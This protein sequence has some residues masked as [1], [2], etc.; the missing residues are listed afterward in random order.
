MVGRSALGLSSPAFW[1]V[2]LSRQMHKTRNRK[3]IGKELGCVFCLFVVAV[4]WFVCLVGW[5]VLGLFWFGF[6]CFGGVGNKIGCDFLSHKLSHSVFGPQL[7][8]SAFKLIILCLTLINQHIFNT[9]HFST[10]FKAF[11]S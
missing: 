6:F 10:N 4:V 11:I 2:L 8:I 3:L 7:C 5:L 1:V 9:S